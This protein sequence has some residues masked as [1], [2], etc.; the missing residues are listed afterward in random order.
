ML[1]KGEVAKRRKRVMDESA[2][3]VTGEVVMEEGG[4]LTRRGGVDRRPWKGG[5]VVD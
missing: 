2:A 1:H 4:W 5:R 3:V